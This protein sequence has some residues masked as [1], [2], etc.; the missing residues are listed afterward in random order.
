[1]TDLLTGPSVLWNVRIPM[2]DGV[3]LANNVYLPAGGLAGGP[4]PVVF[5]RNPYN[6]QVWADVL[7]WRSF[8]ERGYA[9]VSQDCRGRLDS[10]GEFYP[11]LTEGPDAFDS[12]E[13]L[14]EQPWCTGKIGMMG[15]SYGGWVQW[16][17]AKERPPHLTTLVSSCAAG[18]WGQELPW[19]RGGVSLVMFT[20]LYMMIGRSMQVTE[21]VDWGRVFKHLPLRTMD[22][23]LGKEIPAWHDW[24]DHHLLDDYWVSGLL[25]DVFAELD[26][27][28]LHLTGWFDGDQPGQ[29]YFWDGMKRSKNPAGQHLVVGPWT[30]GGVFRPVQTVRDLDFT[31]KSVVDMVDLHLRWFDHWL[32]GIDNGLMDEPPVRYFVTGINEWRE[33]SGWPP[34]DHDELRLYLRSGGAA[35]T[36]LGDGTLSVD[37]PDDDEPEDVYL[38]DPEDVAK[39]ADINF[40]PSGRDLTKPAD[41]RGLELRDDILT[42]TSEPMTEPLHLCGRPTVVLYGSSDCPDTDWVVGLADVDPS[43]RCI[44]LMRDEDHQE[45]VT[46]GG[47]LRAR[48]RDGLDKEVFM[49]AGEVYE[50]RLEI[51][52][53]AHVIKPGHRLRLTVMSWDFP[54][55]ARNLNTDESIADGTAVR[56]ATN[57]VHHTPVWPSYLL[58]PVQPSARVEAIGIGLTS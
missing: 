19:D 6:R 51:R 42:Y 21:Y 37:I 54:T 47:R 43:G 46:Q 31:P 52:D 40:F 29:M 20:W 5:A 48:F 10:D 33:A 22:R 8:T 58:L 44:P 14:A 18:K 30:H 1:M 26:L 39:F 50:F 32:R 16:A 24:L 55:F 56:V 27:P 28:A 45:H 53:I 17:A 9:V 38:Y 15:G 2:R 11:F 49:T 23:A 34:T 25:D 12:I 3:E 36:A 7:G 41:A 13:W 4:Y 35:N 57:R